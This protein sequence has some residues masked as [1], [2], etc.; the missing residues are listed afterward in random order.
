MTER[1]IPKVGDRVVVSGKY[2][3]QIIALACDR[4]AQVH[5]VK[6]RIQH[7]YLFWDTEV[8]RYIGDISFIEACP[9]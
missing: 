8:W 7:G 5:Y 1:R 2:E 9:A 3:S 4:D 6:V